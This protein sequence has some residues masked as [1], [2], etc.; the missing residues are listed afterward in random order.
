MS[1]TNN[2]AQWLYYNSDFPTAPS[3]YIDKIYFRNVPSMLPVLWDFT[4]F[5][6]K[7]GQTALTSLPSGPWVTTGM[8]TV[9]YANTFSAWP[10]PGDWTPVTLQTPFYYD[11]TQNVIVEAS[12]YQ[13]TVGFNVKVAPLPGRSLI[14]NIASMTG[15]AQNTLCEFGFDISLGSTDATLL[16][17]PSVNDTV[18]SGNQLVSVVLKNNGPP[19][20][21]STT[22]QW[23]V[24]NIVQQPVYWTGN[25]APLDT[26]TV[27][28]GNYNFSP[29]SIVSVMA[30]TNNPNNLPDNNPSND[31]ISFPGI[32]VHPSPTITL[33]SNL[34]AICKGDTADIL[35]VLTGANPWHIDY[36]DGGT[37]Y[38]VTANSS[39]FIIPV[40]PS[41]TTTYSI[42]SVTD[43][44]GCT[45]TA[46]PATTVAV[47]PLPSV[48]LGVD[49][50]IKTSQNIT[51]DAGPG[52]TDYQWNTGA[53]TQTIVVNGH[54]LGQGSYP[55]S[56]TV[57]NNHGC[58]ASDTI[59]ITVID[60]VGINDLSDNM[61]CCLS[62]NPAK[63]KV[64]ITISMNN[65]G[66]INL[67]LFNHEGKL[68]IDKNYHEINNKTTFSLDLTSLSPGTYLVQIRCNNRI[69]VEKL[70]I[71]DKHTSN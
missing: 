28:L 62:P 44:H 43:N 33:G 48:N 11:N 65:P 71:T 46:N 18:C 67:K 61:C 24:N 49:T 22:I 45:T 57:T 8:N 9:F 13:Y 59:L 47:F 55:F 60:D 15:T 16:R 34:Y 51:L 31:T 1:N 39:S 66:E 17:F 27:I 26:S 68:V 64:S 58:S 19:T 7:M 5:Q 69:F 6:I 37:Q 25:L 56:V 21:T 29:S 54:T 38:S 70:I 35:C 2:K 30:W 20:M 23:K 14:G 52:F 4:D 50:T 42:L 63:E 41:I 36:T 53:S 3:G 12:H 10:L 40:S 32:Y